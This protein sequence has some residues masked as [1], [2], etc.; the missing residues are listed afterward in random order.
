MGLRYAAGDGRPAT[1]GPVT[2]AECSGNAMDDVTI[3]GAA[4]PNHDPADE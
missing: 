3:R 1:C 4:G 2:L